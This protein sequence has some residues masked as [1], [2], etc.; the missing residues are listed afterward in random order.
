MRTGTPPTGGRRLIERRITAYDDLQPM[1]VAHTAPVHDALAS[2]TSSIRLSSP[3]GAS[4]SKSTHGEAT[5]GRTMDTH[6]F[7]PEPIVRRVRCGC[8]QVVAMLIE[9]FAC[10]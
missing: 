3:V 2:P 1:A 4:T 9:T 7:W 8:A 5:I 10:R 6:G